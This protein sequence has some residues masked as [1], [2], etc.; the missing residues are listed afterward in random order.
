MKIG[1]YQRSER[2]ETASSYRPD[3]VGQTV[4]RQINFQN[5]ALFSAI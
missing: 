3:N 2:R 1:R 4:G 5:Y